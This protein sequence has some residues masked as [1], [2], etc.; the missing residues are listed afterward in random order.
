M[1]RMVKYNGLMAG[2]L[3][4]QCV[5]PTLDGYSHLFVSTG[6]SR[7]HWLPLF[8]TL[9]PEKWNKKSFMADHRRHPATLPSP[10]S[11]C[12]KRHNN[13]ELLELYIELAL[14]WDEESQAAFSAY[15]QA[16]HSTCPN[17]VP[18][19][20]Q[21]IIKNDCFFNLPS[22]FCYDAQWSSAKKASSWLFFLKRCFNFLLQCKIQ[23]LCTAMINV[24][25]GLLQIVDW[26]T[27]RD[28]GHGPRPNRGLSGRR[29]QD[30]KRCVEVAG[31]GC[32]MCFHWP[33]CGVGPCIQG[34]SCKEWVYCVVMCGLTSCSILLLFFFHFETVFG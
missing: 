19:S 32:Q 10:C 31:L 23:R 21:F 13:M 33:S 3:V 11:V 8:S 12:G 6:N 1:W 9:C 20:K 28:R 17:R 7:V 25:P 5:R 24:C 18:T 30:R 22:N 26:C 14:G 2:G 34:T 4:Q 15:F 16:L 29:D 27:V